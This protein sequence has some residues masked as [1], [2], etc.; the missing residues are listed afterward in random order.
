MTRFQNQQLTNS[1]KPHLSGPLF[2]GGY[3]LWHALLCWFA[4]GSYLESSSGKWDLHFT[5]LILIPGIQI[6]A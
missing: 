2:P 6:Y 4:L 3:G 5:F 1:S